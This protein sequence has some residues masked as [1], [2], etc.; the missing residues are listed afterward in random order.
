MGQGEVLIQPRQVL[1]SRHYREPLREAL[2]VS[3]RTG[4]GIDRI[5]VPNAFRRRS[6]ANGV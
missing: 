6:G 5:R 4:S 3:R 1:I 2:T